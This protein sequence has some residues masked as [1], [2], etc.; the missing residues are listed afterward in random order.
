MEN[1]KFDDRLLKILEK[2]VLKEKWKKKARIIGVVQRKRVTKKESFLFNVKTLKSEYD[3]VVPQ[4]KKEEFEI[5]SNI[6][7]GDTIK[8]IGDKQVSG[9][10]FCDRIKRIGKNDKEKQMKINI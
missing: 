6:K 4:Y 8:V 2:E 9:I 10:I 1:I 5:A 3:I 7:E